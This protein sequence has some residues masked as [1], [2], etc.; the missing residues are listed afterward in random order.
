MD[1]INKIC[2][3]IAHGRS[4][5]EL[6]RRIE[7]FR[8]LDVVWCSMSTFE[9]PEKYILSKINKH[10]SIIFDSST[11]QNAIDYE[12]SIRIPRLTE[13]LDRQEDNKYICTKT[14]HSNLYNLR[15][16]LGLDF[17]KKYKDKIICTED[18]G[19]NPIP[20]CVSLHLFIACLH[21]MGAKQIILFGADGGGIYGNSIESYY[22]WKEIER[23]KIIAGNL[24]YN[25]VGDTNNINN[26]Y[27]SLMQQTLGYVPEVLNCS[28]GST[29]TAFKNISYADT[30]SSLKENQ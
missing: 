5:E 4:I 19:V 18:I 6:E 7:E 27:S 24:T 8:D 30:I 21:K 10:F 1:L 12:L 17:N 16:S 14:D 22:K 11:V 9:V 23:D 29:Y 20:F 13:F 15:D 25:M 28:P 26:S 2:L 3:L